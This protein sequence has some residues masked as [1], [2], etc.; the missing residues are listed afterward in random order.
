[1][2]SVISGEMTTAQAP[3]HGRVRLHSL[4]PDA[5]NLIFQLISSR[6][7][8]GL[9]HPD[10]GRHDRRPRV[11]ALIGCRILG[12]VG[13]PASRARPHARRVFVGTPI[14]SSGHWV[15]LNGRR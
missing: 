7:S 15:L 5:A 9:T 2:L 3:R 12:G 1:M 13:A 8:A 10:T 14:A 6:Y 4:R 11:L